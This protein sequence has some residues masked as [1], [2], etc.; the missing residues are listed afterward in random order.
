MPYKTECGPEGCHVVNSDTGRRLNKKPMSK[1]K[2]ERYMKA[3]YANVPEAHKKEH[4]GAMIALML[5]PLV[6]LGLREK[7]R[8]IFGDLA[9]I[10][11]TPLEEMHITLMYLGPAAGLTEQQISDIHTTVGA[12][13]IQWYAD[14]DGEPLYTVVTG[15][16][17]F[18]GSEEDVDPLVYLVS[19]PHLN[20]LQTAVSDAL[21]EIGIESGSEHGFLPHITVGYIPKSTIVALPSFTDGIIE[22]T[23]MTV[24]IGEDH[25]AHKFADPDAMKPVE[26][27]EPSNE[28]MDSTDDMTVVADGPLRDTHVVMHGNIVG[29]SNGNGLTYK[30]VNE[31]TVINK[32]MNEVGPTPLLKE[33]ENILSPPWTA[34]GDYVEKTFRSSQSSS[35]SSAVLIYKTSV[36]YRWLTISS[37]GFE[38][39][40]GEC[41]ATKAL[42]DDCT[43]ADLIAEKVEDPELRWRAYG[44]LTFWHQEDPVFLRKGDWASVIAGPASWAIGKTDTN[45]VH[46]GMLIE[47]GTFFDDSV[48]EALAPVAKSLRISIAFAAPAGSPDEDR[49]YHK[50][51]RYARTLVPL[52]HAVPSNRFT[53]FAPIIPSGTNTERNGHHGSSQ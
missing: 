9:D 8:G 41:I 17:R 42:E 28:M 53:S 25:M 37:N 4:E 30:E 7:S 3:L 33:F 26:A 21:R 29:S 22:H 44:P 12:V 38:D 40:D 35:D 6:A 49:V 39:R 13:G 14:Y 34:A 51:R 11:R 5:D 43:L 16:G 24:C 20:C 2:A 47:S 52:G 31:E 19:G 50:I 45:F 32:T 10:E 1:D 27:T 36:G 48:A 46:E 23:E 15:A 18:V